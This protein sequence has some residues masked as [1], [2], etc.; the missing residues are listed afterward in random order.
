M[1][2]RALKLWL[3]YRNRELIYT[4]DGV[5]TC[6]ASLVRTPSSRVFGWSA[7]IAFSSRRI[8]SVVRRENPQKRAFLMYVY[9]DVYDRLFSQPN[10][11][12]NLLPVSRGIAPM[13]M[14][15]RASEDALSVVLSAKETSYLEKQ[16][17][18]P[19]LPVSPGTPSYP[20]HRP[21]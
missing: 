17:V 2:T 7:L 20:E 14:V 12:S 19:P 4:N 5:H 21:R 11:I 10:A 9:R 18:I 15:L 3:K 13:G 16:T 1:F 6:I 8:N